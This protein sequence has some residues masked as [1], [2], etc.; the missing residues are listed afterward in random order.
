MNDPKGV[1]V[2]GSS[3]QVGSR[4]SEL[5]LLKG[6]EVYGFSRTEPKKILNRKF[7]FKKIDFLSNVKDDVFEDINAEYLFHCAWKTDPVDY[8]ESEENH[9][10]LET[11]KRLV[12]EFEFKGGSK[13][14]IF[15]TCAE[16]S[17]DSQNGLDENFEVNPLSKYAKSKAELLGWLDARGSEFLWIRTFFQFGLNENPGKF[18]PDLIDY[19][20]N[21]RDFNVHAP[22]EVKDFVFIEDVVRASFGLF[23]KSA[24]GVFNLGTGVGYELQDVAK[25][26]FK[27]IETGAKLSINVKNL[28]RQA[29]VAD[30]TKLLEVLPKFQWTNL[31]LA[32]KKT[33]DLRSKTI[34]STDGK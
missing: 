5:L 20:L 8:V 19:A 12:S 1:I 4:L 29:V 33:I 6:F 2:L 7:H 13:S 23:E 24:N 22:F 26:I 25:R 28:S 9:L 21:Q 10:W 14:V 31:D 30:N 34:K 3:G 16:Y 32:L 15:G 17:W 27:E 11:S 18:I